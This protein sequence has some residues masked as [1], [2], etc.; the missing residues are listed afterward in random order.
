MQQTDG[1]LSAGDC[2]QQHL[3][4]ANQAIFLNKA[5]DSLV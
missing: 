2:H 4:F 5:K 1:V 3:P